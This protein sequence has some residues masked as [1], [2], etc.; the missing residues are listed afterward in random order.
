MRIVPF[1]GALVAVSLV[2]A[3]CGDDDDSAD[4]AETTETT[5]AP[6]DEGDDETGDTGGETA[7]DVEPDPDHPYCAIEA[8]VDAIFEEGFSGLT[9]DSTE[10][11]QFA[12]VQDIAQRV[13]D[14]GLIDEAEAVVPDVIASDFEVLVESVRQAAEGDMSGITDPGTDEAGERVDTFCGVSDDE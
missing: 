13:L 10:E 12:A 2:L 9:E 3:G 6:A 7:A 1:A 11:E 5:V 4:D 14:S 8:Q